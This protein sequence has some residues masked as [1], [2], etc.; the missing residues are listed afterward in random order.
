[1]IDAAS[2]IKQ[3]AYIYFEIVT[4]SF[5]HHPKGIAIRCEKIPF[6]YTALVASGRMGAKYG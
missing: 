1:V 6:F 5:N 3:N 2:K 4:R